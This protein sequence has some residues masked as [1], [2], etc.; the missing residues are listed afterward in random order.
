MM[1]ASAL[2]DFGG[3]EAFDI[4]LTA[5][6]DMDDLVCEEVFKSLRKIDPKALEKSGKKQRPRMIRPTRV[7]LI[8]DFVGARFSLG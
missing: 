7:P 2:G 4:L 5:C 3:K 1:A 6:D 8:G